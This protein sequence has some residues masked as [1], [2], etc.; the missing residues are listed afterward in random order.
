[1][2]KWMLGRVLTFVGVMGATFGGAE[3]QT[4]DTRAFASETAARNYLRQ[5][6]TGPLAKAAFLA[7]VEFR[8][9]RENPGLTR[10]QII[11]GY[12]RTARGP[13]VPP[14]RPAGAASAALY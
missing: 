4:Q 6:P 14:G 9:L 5:Y 10:E 8:L 7:L 3:A 12:G 13:G 2:A 11:A 1:M